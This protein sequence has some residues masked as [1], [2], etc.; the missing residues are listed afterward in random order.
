ML[1]ELMIV[2]RG[3]EFRLSYIAMPLVFGVLALGVSCSSPNTGNSPKTNT[4]KSAEPAEPLR[5]PQGAGLVR[6]GTGTVAKAEGGWRVSSKGGG[7]FAAIVPLAH[8]AGDWTA[9]VEAHARVTAGK[10]GIALLT[11]DTHLLDER[12]LEPTADAQS[13]S[14]S[15]SS[16]QNV[17]DLLVRGVDVKVKLSEVV[18]ESVDLVFQGS[19]LPGAASLEKVEVA[20]PGAVVSLGPPVRVVTPAGVYSYGAMI[21]LSLEG[22]AGLLL[23]KAKLKVVHGEIGIGI[24]N[25]D[26]KSFQGQEFFAPEPQSKEVVVAITDPAIAGRVIVRNGKAPGASEALLEAIGVYSV[27]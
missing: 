22:A 17:Q 24:L 4:E 9:I 8:F 25:K 6:I 18:V 2:F 20:Q 21:P 16:R 23:V 19:L 5:I 13:L 12:I 10:M 11:T 1:S 26:I 7:E 15:F 3:H 14:F 27:K